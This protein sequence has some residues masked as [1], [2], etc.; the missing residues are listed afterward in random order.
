MTIDHLLLAAF[1]FY[2]TV[3]V[4]EAVGYLYILL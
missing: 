2:T 3:V 1:V 4:V